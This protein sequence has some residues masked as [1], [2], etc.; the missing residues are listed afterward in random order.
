MKTGATEG[1]LSVPIRRSRWVSFWVGVGAVFVS[2]LMA[3]ALAGLLLLLLSPAG[4]DGALVV[5]FFGFVWFGVFFL[6]LP[7]QKRYARSLDLRRPAIGLADGLLTVPLDAERTLRFK[8]EEPY[9]LTFGW[10][11][12]VVPGGGG[13]TANTRAFLTYAIL[14]QA[15]QQLLLKAEESAREAQAA[16]WPNSTSPSTP[17]LAVRLWACDLVALVEAVRARG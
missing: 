16:G 9:E 5:I 10:Y 4:G 1:S 7:R 15:G 8:L 12:F 3:A 13:P 6:S 14:S 2:L 17:A 11:E